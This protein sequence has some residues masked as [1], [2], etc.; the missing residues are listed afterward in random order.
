MMIKFDEYRQYDAM[1]LADLVRRNE[2][3][4]KELM[5]A[6]IARAE[7]VNPAINA[8]ISPL[9]QQARAA[10]IEPENGRFGAV[11]FLLKDLLADVAGVPTSMGSRAFSD[12]PAAA[13]STL[14]KRFKA[15][16]L[17][18]LG[19]TNTPEFG[20]M[21]VT[22]PEAFGASCN[23]WDL[24][25]TPGGSSGGSAAAV[26]AG[27]V[28]MASGGD[29]GGSI[30]IPAAYCGLFGLKPTRGRNPSGPNY[31]EYWDGATSEHVLTRS[32]RDSAAMLDLTQGAEPGSP[33]LLPA[34]DSYLAAIKQAPRRLRIGYCSESPLGGEVAPQCLAAVE[35][36]AE[37]LQAL[38]H[39]VEYRRPSIDGELLLNS[40]L[41]MYF[42]HTAADVA[43]LRLQRGR[44]ATS[45]LEDNSR[46]L[47][48]LGECLSAGD[49]VAARHQWFQLKQVM[50]VYHQQFDLFMTPAT[51]AMPAKIGQLSMTPGKRLQTQIANLLGPNIARLMKKQLLAITQQEAK[52]N[53]DQTPFTQ[54]AN[55]T[56]QP[57]MSVPLY[58]SDQG[59]PCGV[60]FM[61]PFGD[62]KTLFQLAAELEAAQPW[63]SRVPSL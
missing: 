51:A 8:I 47:A 40:Y 10:A 63:F 37:L 13:D 3:S 36:T 26:A 60:H 29:G 39:H 4:G 49:Y 54:L 58:W 12:I 33:S 46:F 48:L 24:A 62:E 35:Q 57:A 5:E 41:T 28:P 16:G 25:K 31:G 6:A 7:A 55:L 32:V 53:L 43:R 42:G 15:S 30:R 44:H 11:P 27:I 22:E 21:G 9:Y 56:G 38:G 19:K 20:L 50:D 45:Q 59:L 18:I 34:S 23:P 52:K 14:V 61:A 1:G 17:N 2:V